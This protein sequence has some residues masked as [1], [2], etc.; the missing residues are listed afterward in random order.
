MRVPA[1][2]W[3]PGRVA[4]G[5]VLEMGASLDLLPTLLSLAG[6]SPDPGVLIDG[7]DLTPVLTGAGPS[8]RT[9]VHY[10]ALGHLDALRWGPFKAH[11]VTR[12]AGRV[13]RHRRPLLFNVNHD[14]GETTDISVLYPDVV[15][16]M[17]RLRAAHRETLGPVDRRR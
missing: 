5:V 14:P 8:P 1:I 6:V 12:V 11:F 10:Y 17:R 15:R 9:T 7:A 16:G 2:F 13:E 4:P 3:A